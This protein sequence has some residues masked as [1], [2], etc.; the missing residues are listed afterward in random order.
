MASSSSLL[1]NYLSAPPRHL[2]RPRR[3]PSDV[4]CSSLDPPPAV[5]LAVTAKR[6]AVDTLAT[7]DNKQH[8]PPPPPP[9]PL[10][11]QDDTR[12]HHHY[13]S[14]GNDDQRDEFYLN[15]GTAVRTL[16]DDLPAL[17]SRDLNYHI[18]RDDITFA[19]PLNTFQGIDNYRRIFWAL[20]FHGRMLFKEIGLD[21]LRIWQLSD[22]VIL[23]RWNLKGVPRVPWEARGQ[24]Q[25]TSRYKLDRR[26]KI[27]EH[28]VDNLAFNFPKMVPAGSAAVLDLVTASACPP[29]A[30]RSSNPNLRFL[31][32]WGLLGDAAA[33]ECSWVEFY[34]AVKE[35]IDQSEHFPAG[36]QDGLLPCS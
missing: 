3:R 36:T 30:M 11:G 32:R 7:P 8:R 5:V 17:F 2:P 26:G 31:P 21:V 14:S 23:I 25:G 22:D 15:L 12:H 10:R 9:T 1:P 27:Y 33:Y 19:D 13:A 6:A 35:T 34:R 16:R 18:Y 29:V 28:R 20:R 4:I 24:F